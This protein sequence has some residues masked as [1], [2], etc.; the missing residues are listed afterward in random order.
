MQQ[1]PEQVATDF[2]EQW[3]NSSPGEILIAIVVAIAILIIGR[4][5]ARLIASALERALIRSEIDETLRNFLKQLVYFSLLGIVFLIVLGYLGIPTTSIIAILGATTLAI[6][7]ALQDTLSNFAS[8]ILII[9]LK[10]YRVGDLVE[11]SDE[12]GI[13][14]QVGFFHTELRTPENKILLIPNGDVMDGNI[15]NYSEMEWLRVDLIFGIG[16][17]D[18]LRLAKKILQEIVDNDPR[19][20]Q[21]PPPTIAVQEL[22]DNSVNIAVY[23]FVKL[24]D[25]IAVQFDLTEKVKLRFDEEGISFPYPQRDV[26]LIGG[27]VSANGYS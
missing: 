15:T 10:T 21:D 6:G 11:I 14:R 9:F 13:V 1:D 19:I 16:Y 4:W 7:L 8:G 12:I 20:T 2:F 24:E 27:Q 25:R 26:H 17:D 22:G 5:I 3:T 23:P 18:D